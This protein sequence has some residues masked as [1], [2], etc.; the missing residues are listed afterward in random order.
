LVTLAS[1]DTIIRIDMVG[2]EVGAGGV[3]VCVTWEKE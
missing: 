1:V 2:G 3:S